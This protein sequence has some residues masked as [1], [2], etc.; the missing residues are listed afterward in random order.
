MNNSAKTIIVGNY[1]N[2]W[3]VLSLCSRPNALFVELAMTTLT[4]H[5][6]VLKYILCKSTTL[7]ITCE[8]KYCMC[9]VFM[10]R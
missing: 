10:R 9:K 3:I 5:H 8:Y 4:G 7:Q 6:M 1:L 2:Q